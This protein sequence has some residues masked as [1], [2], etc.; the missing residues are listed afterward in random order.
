MY[1]VPAMRRKD[2][3][4]GLKKASLTRVGEACCKMNLEK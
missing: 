2:E 4:Q 1:R 3:L